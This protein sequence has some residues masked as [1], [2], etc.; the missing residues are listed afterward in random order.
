K[1]ILYATTKVREGKSYVVRNRSPHDRIL[2]VEHPFRPGYTLVSPG[3]AAERT[4]DLYRFEV[5]VPAGKTV[6]LEVV[7]ERTVVVR[8][9]LTD[10]DDQTVLRY[11]SSASPSSALRAALNKARELK[12][13]LAATRR[14]IARL[15]RQLKRI[16]EDQARLR[17]NMER[18]PKE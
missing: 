10:A 16:T 5:K 6:T 17:A 14:A 11:L 8:V 13:K 18:V 7:E 1:G 9:V 2:L 12:G 15:E 3:K 4:R